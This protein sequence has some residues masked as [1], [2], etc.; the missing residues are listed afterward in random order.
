MTAVIR[1]SLALP[2]VPDSDVRAIAVY[3]SEMDLAATRGSAIEA[4]TRQ[5]LEISGLDSKQGQD[6]DADLYVSAC[7]SCH[8][9]SGLAPLSERPELALNSAITLPEPTNF[10]QTVLNGVGAKEG[11]PGLVMPE[12]AS[13]LSDKEIARLAAY[14]RRTRTSNQPWTDLESKVAKIRRA[15]ALR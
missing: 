15:S 13:S 2:V 5:A 7:I 1:D 6:P 9:N 11:A 12:Y 10:I 8:Y 14:L 4:K 3:F